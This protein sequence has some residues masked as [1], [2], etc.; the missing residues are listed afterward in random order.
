VV[1]A[2]GVLRPVLAAAW[3]KQAESIEQTAWWQR[4][5]G[6]PTPAQLAWVRETQ[7]LAKAYGELDTLIDLA[8]LPCTGRAA[9]LVRQDSAECG[10]QVAA[11]LA[12]SDFNLAGQSAFVKGQVQARIEKRI[13]APSAE[14]ADLAFATNLLPGLLQHLNKEPGFAFVSTYIQGC[15]IKPVQ[16]SGARGSLD[17]LLK[18]FPD[19]GSAKNS[20]ELQW[21]ERLQRGQNLCE[22][23]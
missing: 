19:S 11:V 1:C 17:V 10:R 4:N 2:F 13:L 6:K 9:P 7:R 20:R 8:A 23:P 5:A 16:I 22:A 21:P 18:D 12:H 3:R 15:L 14:H